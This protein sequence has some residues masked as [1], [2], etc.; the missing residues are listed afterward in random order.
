MR[1]SNGSLAGRRTCIMTRLQ[2]AV[3]VAHSHEVVCA[4]VAEV[5]LVLRRLK[6]SALFVELLR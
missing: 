6:Q 3:M 1:Q 4:V 5:G 2:G